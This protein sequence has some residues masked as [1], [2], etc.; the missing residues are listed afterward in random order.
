MRRNDDFLPSED[1][2]R[3]VSLVLVFGSL[4]GGLNVVS[5]LISLAMA[6]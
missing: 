5:A 6:T 2:R 1:K 3:P 4:V